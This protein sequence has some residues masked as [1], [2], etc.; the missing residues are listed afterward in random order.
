MEIVIALFL[1]PLALIAAAIAFGLIAGVGMLASPF[2]FVFAVFTGNWPLAAG[3][4][5]FLVALPF[6]VH[7]K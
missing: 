7:S 1:I 6:V 4:L 2:V 5:P 3:C